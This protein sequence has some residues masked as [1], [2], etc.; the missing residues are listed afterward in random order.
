MIKG[1]KEIYT[2]ETPSDKET[3]SAEVQPVSG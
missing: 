1:I 2:F 3:G